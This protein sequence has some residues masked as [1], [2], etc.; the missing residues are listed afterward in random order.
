MAK[1][2]N[3]KRDRI[4]PSW[5]DGEHPVSELAADRQGA[6][7]PYGEVTFPLRDVPYVHPKTEIN[8]QPET[9]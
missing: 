5:P 7:S 6:L 2:D 3:G 8:W 9:E 1:A 4:D